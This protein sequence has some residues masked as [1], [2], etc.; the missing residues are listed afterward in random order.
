MKVEETAHSISAGFTGELTMESFQP[1]EDE[2]KTPKTKD[3]SPVPDSER[4]GSLPVKK[5]YE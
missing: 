1:L 4:P 2:E 5:V 3:S